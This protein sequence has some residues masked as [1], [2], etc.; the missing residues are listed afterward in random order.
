M[1]ASALKQPAVVAILSVF[2]MCHECVNC[3]CIALSAA[4]VIVVFGLDIT[5]EPGLR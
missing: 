5:S 4:A 1:D 3:G 2:I